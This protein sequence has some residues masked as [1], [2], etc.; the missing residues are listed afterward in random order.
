M[1][2]LFINIFGTLKNFKFQKKIF[3]N[4]Q[5]RLKR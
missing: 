4:T 2:L 3:K 1:I 5:S